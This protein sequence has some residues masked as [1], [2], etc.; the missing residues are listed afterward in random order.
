MKRRDFLARTGALSAASLAGMTVY[1]CN[2]KYKSAKEM[3]V[4]GPNDTINLGFIGVGLR[5]MQ[6]FDEFKNLPGT[7]MVAVSD[8]DDK[9]IER[10]RNMID[11]HYNPGEKSCAGYK[12]FRELLER[13]DIDGVV[14]VTP[15]HWHAIMTIMAIR[16]GKDVYCEKPVSHTIEEGRAIVE[17]AN[18]YQ[19]IVQV[20]S[21]QRSH[22][23]FRTAVNYVRNGYIGELQAVKQNSSD[24]LPINFKLKTTT[25]PESMDWDM[26]MGPAPYHDYN[27]LLCPDVSNTDWPKWR[28]FREWGGGGIADLGVHMCDIGQWA[29]DMDTSGPV[30][31]IPKGAGAETLT[32]KYA[33]GI[34]M[35]Q[36][37][38]GMGGMSIMFEGIEG[39][40]AAGRWWMRTCDALKDV[41]LEEKTGF[42]YHSE[43]H[44]KDWIDCMRS[45]KQPICSP[46]TGHRSATV[47]NMAI[48][49]GLL[50]QPLHWDPETE[51]FDNA[52]ANKMKHYKYRGNWKIH[53]PWWSFLV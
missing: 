51:Q 16:H 49:A 7:R 48:I 12:D 2:S 53:E 22:E 38:F 42:V 39:W 8:I 25:P 1:S 21:Q 20:G 6:L 52:E 9:R 47:C 28:M 33:N 4:P 17:A 34:E 43:D 3:T 44:A 36:E 31:I 26:W 24:V 19:R 14:V 50:E 23:A 35:K 15:D 30:E 32:F 40:V 45:R 41:P 11:A 18:K 5:F 46:E 10:A 37:D 13:E 27:A 29:M